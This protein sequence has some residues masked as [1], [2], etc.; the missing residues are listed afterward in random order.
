MKI[1][2]RE[3]TTPD[4]RSYTVRSARPREAGKILDHAWRVRAEPEVSVED[5]DEFRCDAD[6]LR[7]ILKTAL[8]ADNGFFLVAA[9]G[10]DVVAT[11]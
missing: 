11:L 5:Q 8:E 2:P 6:Q 1:P 9:A 7:G 3:F 10:D 4:G